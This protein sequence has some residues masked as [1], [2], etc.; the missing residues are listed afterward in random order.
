M[1][2]NTISNSRSISQR[3]TAGLISLLI[4]VSMV[5]AVGL[6]HISAVHNAAHD[7]RHAIGFPC[8]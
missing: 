7:T 2:T 4:G 3:A 1:T 6:S 5:F 8:H